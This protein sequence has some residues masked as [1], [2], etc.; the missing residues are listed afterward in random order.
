[1]GSCLFRW[2]VRAAGVRQG[3]SS[4]VSST[5]TW[6][7][8]AMVARQFPIWIFR[9][10]LWV[11]IPRWSPAFCGQ[12]RGGTSGRGGGG[13]GSCDSAWFALLM[14]ALAYP[15]SCT[16]GVDNAP[17]GERARQQDGQC[18]TR[19][20]RGHVSSQ[21]GGAELASLERSLSPTSRTG[22]NTIS[23]SQYP[24]GHNAHASRFPRPATKETW[25]TGPRPAWRRYQARSSRTPSSTSSSA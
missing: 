10:R 11:R 12:E 24:R 4:V 20:R 15:A 19:M 14:E 3:S 13:T 21:S 1:M 22:G 8:G 7:P 17:V 6:P 5:S 9:W 16:R 25:C 23:V 18:T 2:W